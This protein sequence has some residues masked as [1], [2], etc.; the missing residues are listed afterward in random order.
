M[1]LTNIIF[2]IFL[3]EEITDVH[4]PDT[5]RITI[6]F[7]YFNVDYVQIDMSDASR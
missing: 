6:C 3:Y 1:I 5:F 2:Y 7:G 4:K